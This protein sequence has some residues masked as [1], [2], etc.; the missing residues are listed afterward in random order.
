MEKER[1]QK[2][3][4]S[5]FPCKPLTSLKQD[6][7][8]RPLKCKSPVLGEANTAKNKQTQLVMQL[9]LVNTFIIH[10]KTRT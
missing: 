4:P 8:L 5:R 9:R 2:L 10:K 3:G 7:G 6:V 1:A